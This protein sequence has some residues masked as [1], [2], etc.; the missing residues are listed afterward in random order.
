[1]RLQLKYNC[2]LLF[3]FLFSPSLISG[4]LMFY[5]VQY[6]FSLSKN[7]VKYFGN[8]LSLGNVKEINSTKLKVHKYFVGQ[9]VNIVD[10]ADFL[11]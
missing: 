6:Q 8:V 5:F 3:F 2:R 7:D 1:M 9:W 10:T 11:S 4:C